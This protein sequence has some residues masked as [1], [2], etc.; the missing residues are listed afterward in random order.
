M[1]VLEWVFEMFLWLILFGCMSFVLAL[2]A[3]F[4]EWLMCLWSRD[5]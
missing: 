2:S 4:V 3:M 1:R 5:D